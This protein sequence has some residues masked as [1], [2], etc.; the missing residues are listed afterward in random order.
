[1]ENHLPPLGP[2]ELS[3]NDF[4]DPLNYTLTYCSVDDAYTII[5]QLGKGVLLSKIDLKNA[6]AKFLYVVKIGTS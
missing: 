3:I 1:M 4:I 5:N 2:Y 6:S